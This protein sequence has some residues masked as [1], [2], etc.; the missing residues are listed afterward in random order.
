M[1][2]KNSKRHR[3]GSFNCR[4]CGEPQTERLW[5]ASYRTRTCVFC[6]FLAKYEDA[7]RWL[8]TG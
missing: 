1:A 6:Y 7:W 4:E 2:R 8:A 3:Y 5:S